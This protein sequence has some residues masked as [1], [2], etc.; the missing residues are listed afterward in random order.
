MNVS[1]KMAFIILLSAFSLSIPAEAFFNALLL[2]KP[3][4]TSCDTSN[5]R[6]IQRSSSN[7][8]GT[9][10][11]TAVSDYLAAQTAGNTN[12]VVISFGSTV[13]T[14]SSVTDTAGNTYSVA[15]GP[16][17]GS[18]DTLYIFYAKNIA[19]SAAGNE[20]TVTFNQVTN[21]VWVELLEYAGLNTSNPF[22]AASS[23]TGTSATATG[24]NLVTTNACDLLISAT[25][26]S[27]NVTSIGAGYNLRADT[28]GNFVQDR[29][30]SSTGTYT[31]T[32]TISNSGNWETGFVAFKKSSGTQALNSIRRIQDNFDPYYTPT[33]STT[34]V[35]YPA[36]QTAGNLNVVV[37]SWWDTTGTVSSVTDTSGNTYTLVAGPIRG[38]G[39]THYIYYAKNIAS[40]SAGGN[41]VTVTL[42]ASKQLSVGILEYTGLSTT[43]PLDQATSSTAYTASPNSG[44]V[45]TTAA[46]ELIL[47]IITSSSNG[48]LRPTTGS[49]FSPVYNHPWVSTWFVQEK[50]VSSTGTYSS[51]ASFLNGSADVIAHIVTFK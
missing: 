25:A 3:S 22:D 23:A 2:K 21:W 19:S 42:S 1:F 30:V 24:G 9:A 43:S 51:T 4:T 29:V 34:S 41:S 33:R 15:V 7:T 8:A 44:S 46:H 27:D 16:I 32:S 40:A 45:T 38:T 17:R 48:Y 5:A 31:S 36:P 26:Q 12:V 49:G 13:T 39:L 37:V 35:P 6:A 18:S 11:A 50:V 20:V 28:W 47:G 10:S 14:V